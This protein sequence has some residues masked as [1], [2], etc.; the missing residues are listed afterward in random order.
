MSDPVEEVVAPAAIERA[1]SQLDAQW[2]A[3]TG[4]SPNSNA[5]DAFRPAWT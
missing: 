1:L 5:R 3:L 2:L 4:V